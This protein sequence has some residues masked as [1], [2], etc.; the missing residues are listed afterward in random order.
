[1]RARIDHKRRKARIRELITAGNSNREIAA[2]VGLT[3]RTLD[4]YVRRYG[5]SR[6]RRHL[7]IRPVRAR[8]I[9]ATG[10]LRDCLGCGAKVSAQGGRWLCDACR[11]RRASGSLGVPEQWLQTPGHA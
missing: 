10:G 2:A 6:L 9:P 11:A 5:L 1:M 7:G 4:H 8:R 3:L